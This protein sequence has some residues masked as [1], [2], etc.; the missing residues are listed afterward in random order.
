MSA[1]WRKAATVVGALISL[2]SVFWV[3]RTL[4]LEPTPL[5]ILF[6]DAKSIIALVVS[7]AIYALSLILLAFN[8]ARLVDQFGLTSID[9]SKSMQSYLTSQIAKY[10]PGNFA[11]YV[12]R[13]ISGVKSG[14][15][16]KAL[17]YAAIDEAVLL[18]VAASIVAFCAS[19]FVRPVEIFGLSVTLVAAIVAVAGGLGS[20]FLAARSPRSRQHIVR[21]RIGVL[22]RAIVFMVTMGFL[23]FG[24]L[25]A[26]LALPL[27]IGATSIAWLVGFVTPGS[28]GGIGTREGMLMILLG[29]SVPAG[30]LALSILAFRLVTVLGDTVAFGLSPFVHNISLTR[31]RNV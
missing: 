19:Q 27:V 30:Q 13:H 16:H 26:Q 2:L 20:T 10:L 31:S 9:V 7:A 17:T 25:G 3:A 14:A 12:G 23:L 24:L 4:W 29:G 15:S 8:W 11:H 18:L 5:E 28:P 22:A 21:I 6:P 1:R